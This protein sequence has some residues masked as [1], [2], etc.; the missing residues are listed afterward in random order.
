MQVCAERYATTI[1]GS[2]IDAA[3]NLMAFFEF[4]FRDAKSTRWPDWRTGTPYLVT[5][6][7]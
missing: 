5:P 7:R 6:T 2:S 3:W 1:S 4:K